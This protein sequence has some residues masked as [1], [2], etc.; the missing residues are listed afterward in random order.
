MRVFY[1]HTH[2][3]V[4]GRC[5]YAW[6]LVLLSWKYDQEVVQKE[7]QK[8]RRGWARWGRESGR[9]QVMWVQEEERCCPGWSKS[10]HLSEDRFIWL[11]SIGERRTEAAQ[12]RDLSWS[13]RNK[14]SKHYYLNL[15]NTQ[16]PFTIINSPVWYSIPKPYDWRQVCSCSNKLLIVLPISSFSIVFKV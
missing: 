7:K 15:E 10:G 6:V 16:I 9:E 8:K 11:T 4:F 12:I 3:C 5:V 13:S 2:I 1:F 14:P